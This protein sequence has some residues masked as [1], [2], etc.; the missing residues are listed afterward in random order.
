MNPPAFRGA[1]PAQEAGGVS[2][3]GGGRQGAAE[4]TWCV[5]PACLHVALSR[6]ADGLGGGTGMAAWAGGGA[7]SI[8]LRARVAVRRRPATPYHRRIASATSGMCSD[9]NQMRRCL[10][11]LA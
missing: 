1:G 7:G 3:G 10:V 5:L 4:V 11:G 6:C 2:R 9:D 8:Y